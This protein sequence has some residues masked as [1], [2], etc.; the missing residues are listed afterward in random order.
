LPFREGR[1]VGKQA[2]K[3]AR[4]NRAPLLGSTVRP[5][6]GDVSSCCVLF[7]T[8]GSDTSFL[9]LK[10]SCPLE[11]GDGGLGKSSGNATHRTHS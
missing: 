3:Q 7:H 6:W 8:L 1:Y 11:G 2:S 4:K 5:C 10:Q 9:S